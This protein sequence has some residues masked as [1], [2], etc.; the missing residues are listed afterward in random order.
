[1]FGFIKTMF[2]TGLTVLSYVNPLSTNQLSATPL[3]CISV[4][5]QEYKVRPK[6]INVNSNEPVIYH[7]SVKTSKYSG[8]CNN[9][10]DQYAKVPVP[11]VVRNLNVK[12][13]SNVKN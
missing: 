12:A 11:D 8:S 3:S 13:L 1:M 4:N 9:V 6:I 2:L 5:N 10:N 7:F